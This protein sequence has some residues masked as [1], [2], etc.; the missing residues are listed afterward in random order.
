MLPGLGHGG[1]HLAWGAAAKAVLRGREVVPSGAEARGREFGFSWAVIECSWLI[2]EQSCR[3]RKIRQCGTSPHRAHQ[4]KPGAKPRPIPQGRDVPRDCHGS[5]QQEKRAKSW[6][7][8]RSPELTPIFTL[9]PQEAAGKPQ[10]PPFQLQEGARSLLAFL[11][12]LGAA[13][14][15]AAKPRYDPAGWTF[16]SFFSAGGGRD[17]G[18]NCSDCA[19]EA[20]ASLLWC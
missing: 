16:S 19:G 9:A 13:S 2:L 18:E 14:Q 4:H 15:F 11:E 10:A 17:H 5:A 8:L 12:V 3:G 6:G 1:G 20:F 7:R